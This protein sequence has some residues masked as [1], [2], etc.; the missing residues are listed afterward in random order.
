MLILLPVYDDT[1]DRLLEVLLA[2]FMR[3]SL[4]L[5]CSHLWTVFSPAELYSPQAGLLRAAAQALVAV[6]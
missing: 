6:T 5:T 2:I 4:C 1:D 3:W